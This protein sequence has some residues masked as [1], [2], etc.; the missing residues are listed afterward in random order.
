MHASRL[1]S[2][3][4]DGHRHGFTLVELL[5]VIGIIAVLIA[6]LLPA[7]QQA[8][9]Q[10]A[11]VQCQSNM[12][13]IAMAVIMYTDASKGKH[14]PANA[15]TLAGP[16]PRGWWWPNE[17][18]RGNYIKAPSVYPEPGWS[19]TDKRFNR[20]NVFRCPEGIDEDALKGNAGNWPTDPLN[21]GYSLDNDGNSAAD[22][23]L[24]WANGPGW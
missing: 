13:Q 14:M 22:G 15:P 6:I 4:D 16:Y 20:S 17:L 11:V 8:R 19:T 21:N 3:R 9:R 23:R 24:Q 2:R 5:V 1:G 12:R 10:A 18:V 7:L